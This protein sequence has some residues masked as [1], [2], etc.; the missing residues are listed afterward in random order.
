MSPGRLCRD[1]S[2]ASLRGWPRPCRDRLP[3]KGGF[4]PGGIL[5]LWLGLGPLGLHVG[6]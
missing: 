2:D 6:P 5:L 4:S 3:G 1:A